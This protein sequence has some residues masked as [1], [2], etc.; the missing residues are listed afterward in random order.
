[1]LRCPGWIH[2][3]RS[4]IL[5]RSS[6]KLW[7]Y[8]T[9]SYVGIRIMCLLDLCL[10]SL[11]RQETGTT[12]Y[13][14]LCYLWINKDGLKSQMWRKGSHSLYSSLL[15][16]RLFGLSPD[17]LCGIHSCRGGPRNKQEIHHPQS[18]PMGG[19]EFPAFEECWPSC[20]TATLWLLNVQVSH[21]VS[22]CHAFRDHI[23]ERVECDFLINATPF[24]YM[25][26]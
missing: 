3:L 8:V 7:P 11:G 22:D 1:M 4:E 10:F 24:N 18:V 21:V 6:K 16:W 15:L 13:G 26:Y 14:N 23:W 5:I 2:D 25:R 9:I 19:E 12:F 17:F 20:H